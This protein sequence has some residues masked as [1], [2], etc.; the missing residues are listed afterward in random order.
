MLESHSRTGG[1]VNL[2]ESRP[3]D[4]LRTG[5]WLDGGWT[6][7]WIATSATPPRDDGVG[8][9]LAMMGFGVIASKL[10]ATGRAGAATW[11]AAELAKGRTRE[12]F[13]VG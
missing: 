5:Y 9:G 4:R 6:A 12:E 8:G 7:C 13:A 3:F 1:A 2:V 10:A 11:L